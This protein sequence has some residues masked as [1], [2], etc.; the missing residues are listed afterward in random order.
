MPEEK[1]FQDI[2]ETVNF[3]KEDADVYAVDIL[4]LNKRV[5]MLEQQVQKLQFA[6]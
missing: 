2:L 4:D 6:H 3:I 1:I 5:K